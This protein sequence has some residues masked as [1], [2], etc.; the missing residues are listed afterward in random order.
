MTKE[1][2]VVVVGCGGRSRAHIL[3]YQYIENAKVVACCAPSPERRDKLAAEFGLHAYASA[4]EMI[5]K[6]KTGY[7]TPGHLAGYA[8][9]IND[10][11]L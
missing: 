2:R 5:A 10:S 3:P 6:E 7:G 1:Y 11:G 8:G 9:G 4:K